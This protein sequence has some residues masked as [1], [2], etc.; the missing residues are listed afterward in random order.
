M[1]VLAFSRNAL[2]A[3]DFTGLR[4]EVVVEFL[5]FRE[6]SS[7]ILLV[8]LNVKCKQ[9]IQVNVV[10]FEFVFGVCFHL[11]E[12]HCNLFVKFL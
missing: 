8:L 11:L 2:D 12:Q 7:P 1:H 6:L 9:A 3:N 5:I 4:A 10:D